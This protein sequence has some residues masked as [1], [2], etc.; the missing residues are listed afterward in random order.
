MRSHTGLPTGSDVMFWFDKSAGE[1]KCSCNGRK[2]WSVCPVYFLS[3]CC[4]DTC[5]VMSC[6]IIFSLQFLMISEVWSIFLWQVVGNRILRVP[7]VCRQIRDLRSNWEEI[8]GL[9]NL[10]AQSNESTTTRDGNFPQTKVCQN[11][12]YLP[13]CIIICLASFNMLWMSHNTD[14]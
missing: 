4:T 8:K 9:E 14:A 11:Y 5:L 10:N 12:T 3:V 2:H 6:L 1:T 13:V 7:D